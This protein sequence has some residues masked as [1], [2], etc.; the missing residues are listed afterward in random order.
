LRARPE[1]TQLEDISNAPFLGKLLVLPAN[2]RL[3]WKVFARCKHSSLF[4]LVISNEEKSFI[5]LTPGI[6]QMVGHFAKLVILSTFLSTWHLSTGHF[7]NWP[8]LQEVI[9]LLVIWSTVHFNNK[10]FC[11]VVILP[12][13][14]FANR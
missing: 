5:T 7:A 1:Q 2:D 11:Q 12:T 14:Q 9:S 10:S 8:F 13:G 4:G 3:D 6:C